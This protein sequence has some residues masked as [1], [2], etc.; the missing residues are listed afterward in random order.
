[1][2]CRFIGEDLE[3]QT[4]QEISQTHSLSVKTGT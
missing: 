2:T 3:A 1:M 4:A